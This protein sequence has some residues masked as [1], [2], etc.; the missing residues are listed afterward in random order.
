MVEVWFLQVSSFHLTPAGWGSSHPGI[1]HTASTWALHTINVTTGALAFFGPLKKEAAG[2]AL[3]LIVKVSL[4]V[5]NSIKLCCWH[6]VV[7]DQSD[8]PSQRNASGMQ[9]AKNH[10]CDGGHVAISVALIEP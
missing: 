7:V 1:T 4:Q 10:C 8:N 5:A 6:V 9:N 2:S 3:P